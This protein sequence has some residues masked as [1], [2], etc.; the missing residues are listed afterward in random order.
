MKI[1]VNTLQRCALC[2]LYSCYMNRLVSD[3][4]RAGIHVKQPAKKVVSRTV[5]KRIAEINQKRGERM[6][7]QRKKNE[8]SARKNR[9]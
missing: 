6:T 5:A 8:E 1:S 2:N 3:P 9:A 7:R 4:N